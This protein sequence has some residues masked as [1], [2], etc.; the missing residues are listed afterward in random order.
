PEFLVNKKIGPILF[1]S[2]HCDRSPLWMLSII[3]GFFYLTILG[4]VLKKYREFSKIDFLV[5]ALCFAS[6]VLIL[7]PEQLYVKDIY[8]SHY[9]ANT[10]FKFGYQ[11]FIILSLM[12]G[13]MLV[14]IFRNFKRNSWFNIYYLVIN[15]CKEA[16]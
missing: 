10:V 13:Y 7:I 11:A 16:C 1:E 14:S 3:Y 8:P 4:F 12:S 2:N 9:R 15:T 5:L 6:T